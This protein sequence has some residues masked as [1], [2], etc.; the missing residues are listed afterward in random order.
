MKYSVF[1]KIETR[2]KFFDRF[3]KRY[4][5]VTDPVIR[6]RLIESCEELMELIVKMLLDDNKEDLADILSRATPSLRGCSL[7]TSSV[8]RRST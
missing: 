2:Y 6:E 3:C 1:H 8:Q 4:I 7:I 5:K